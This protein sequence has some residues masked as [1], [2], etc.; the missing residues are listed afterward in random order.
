[1]SKGLFFVEK[2]EC[3]ACGACL[4]VCRKGA[5]NIF[6]GSYALIDRDKCV[7][8]GMCFRECPASAIYKE[9]K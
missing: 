4:K 6:K 2:N 5:V 9:E 7:G 1:M 3:A 8:C